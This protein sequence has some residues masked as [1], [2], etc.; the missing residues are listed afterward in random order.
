MRGFRPIS[1]IN[2]ARSAPSM[3]S[4]FQVASGIKLLQAH[5]LELAYSDRQLIFSFDSAS[6]S[7]SFTNKNL[8]IAG[9]S[10]NLTMRS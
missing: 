1:S 6:T 10:S 5:A 4:W 3:A 7:K 8:S 9:I 2:A